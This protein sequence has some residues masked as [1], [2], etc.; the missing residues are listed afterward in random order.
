[1]L[2]CQTMGVKCPAFAHAGVFEATDETLQSFFPD[3]RACA[4]CM[5]QTPPKRSDLQDDLFQVGAVVL[6]EKGPQFNPRHESGAS[7]RSFIRVRIC[8]ALTDA[9][10]REVKQSLREVAMSYA[11]V[12]AISAS[13]PA[14]VF[15]YPDPQGDFE[16]RL[17]TDLSFTDA[18]PDILKS[19]TP[20]E[21]QVF[22]FLRQEWQH[23]E[24]AETLNLSKG[25]VSQVV[26]QIHVKLATAGERLDFNVSGG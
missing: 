12:D 1:M 19:L 24:I 16:D 17:A 4:A 5:S 14:S 13:H 21:R 10:K 3:L 26:K 23:H 25:R 11:P 15:E 6:I 20:R 2:K 8:G 22:S 18:L 7:F 9:K